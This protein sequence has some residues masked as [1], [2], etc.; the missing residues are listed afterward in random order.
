VR[1]LSKSKVLAGWQCHKRLWLE[2]HAPER[3]EYS[4]AT[5]RAFSIGHEVGDLARRLFPGGILIGH[6]TELSAALAQTA[7]L[8]AR[9]G[10]LTLYEGTFSHGGVLIR[11]DI[12]VRDAQGQVRLVEVKSSTKVKPVNHID[13]AVQAWVLAGAG[14]APARIELGHINSQFVYPGGDDYDGLLTF[15][16][17]T[18]KVLPLLDEVPRWLAA[19]REMLAGEMPD[20]RVGP[21]CRN[22]YECAF[23]GWCTPPQPDYPVSR[24]PNGG[25]V[26]WQLLE[27]GIDD[28]RDVPPGVLTSEMQEWIRRVTVAGRPE[29]RPAA[30][31]ALRA[32]P[33]PRYYFDFETVSFA[34]P[35]WA[36]TRPYQA[37]PFQWSCHVET[38]PGELEHREFLADGAE[39]PM[40][41]C[42]E[43]LLEALG[44][45]G[46]VMVYTTYEA[47]VLRQLAAMFPDLAPRLEAVVGRIFDLHPLVKANYYHPD[48]LGS[49]SIKAVLPTVAPDLD[50]GALGEIQEG[51]AAS[52]AFVEI[53][54]RETSEERR[55]ALRAALR[56]Y[57]ALD[58]LAM[59]RVAL[60]LA[61]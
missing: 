13:C 48:M 61:G 20:I 41:E 35:I 38:A 45:S 7:E 57:C 17:L 10:P 55:Q 47:T 18:D 19:Y 3:A 30:A 53:M 15:A 33:W 8:V 39:P 49:W 44:E 6:D 43:T 5:Q 23:I 27:A 37:L 56:R 1:H 59:V 4:A 21:Q 22:P 60:A 42:A 46:P 50:Y 34:V 25:K 11:A 16:D 52:E 40:R 36:G 29:L 9:P 14:L 32:L 26:V 2:I 24:L 54:A 12:I 28:I 58:T 51:Q 31:E